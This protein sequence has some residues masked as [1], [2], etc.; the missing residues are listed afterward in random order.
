LHIHGIGPALVTP[1]ARLFGLTVVVTHHG[2]DYDRQK[3]GRFG[4]W[5]LRTGEAWGMRFASGRIAISQTIRDIVQRKHGRDCDL[6]ANGVA[7]PEVPATAASLASFGLTPGRYV[8]MVSRLV[9]EKRHDELIAAFGIAQLEGWKLVLVGASDH[10]D[11]YSDKIAALASANPD[12]IT[13]GFQ[14]GVALRELYAHAGLF[15]L[16]SSHEGLP[17]VLLEALSYGLPVLASDIP[18][19]LEIGLA[20]DHYFRMGDIDALAARLNEFAQAPW[21]ADQREKT[22]RWV[23]DRYDWRSV[24]E[25]TLR[26]YRTALADS[27]NAGSGR[28]DSDPPARTE[29]G[30]NPLMPSNGGPHLRPRQDP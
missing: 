1:L 22:K 13:A 9:P 10:P 25:Q 19:N 5:A 15:V 26:A 29:R 6:I 11:A 4:R 24:A 28:P 17:I 20:A 12:V 16:P 18:A 27:L 21:S 14:T 2:P 7:I 23:A 30:K 3:W 8:L